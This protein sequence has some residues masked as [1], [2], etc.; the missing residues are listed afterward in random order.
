MEDGRWKSVNLFESPGFFEAQLA[1]DAAA[2]TSE[3]AVSQ[4]AKPAARET[5]CG[6]PVWKSAIRQGRTA[7]PTAVPAI[8][9]HGPE[10]R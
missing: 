10:R 8:M 4:I 3:S 2:Q 7:P 5:T 9:G 1:G 6:L